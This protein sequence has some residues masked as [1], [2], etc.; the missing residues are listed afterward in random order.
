MGEGYKRLA[1]DNKHTLP[2]YIRACY[3]QKALD[4]FSRS[5]DAL[6]LDSVA[7][8][9]VGQVSAAQCFIWIDPDEAIRQ[10]YQIRDLAVQFYPSLLAKI[11]RTIYLA[12]L[13]RQARKND[14][15]LLLDL[16]AKRS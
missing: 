7:H 1:F 12:K 14:P 9:L 5:W 6:K 2:V 11:D 15:P 4:S 13:R 8:Y 3:A 10:T 16:D